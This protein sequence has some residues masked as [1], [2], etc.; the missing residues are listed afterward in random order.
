MCGSDD[1]LLKSINPPS[2]AG[3]Y[4]SRNFDFEQFLGQF[5]SHKDELIERERVISNFLNKNGTTR[6]S[7]SSLFS[8]DMIRE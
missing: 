6:S 1:K 3:E 8:P 7:V 5:E 4:T 2:S